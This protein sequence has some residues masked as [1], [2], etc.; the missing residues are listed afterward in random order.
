MEQ[1]LEI[2]STLFAPPVKGSI[3]VLAKSQ[4]GFMSMF[5]L[6]LFRSVSEIMPEMQFAVDQMESNKK[7]WE[8]KLVDAEHAEKSKQ[9]VEEM[10][11]VPSLNQTTT[12][13]QPHVSENVGS[14]SSNMPQ[15]ITTDS[16][17]EA[18][19]IEPTSQEALQ[20]NFDTRTDIFIAGGTHTYDPSRRSSLGS[21]H[22][23]RSSLANSL[24]NASSP[25]RASR[26]SSGAFPSTANQQFQPLGHSR[27]SSMTVPSSQLHLAFD[28]AIPRK[29]FD[30]DLEAAGA[31]DRRRS[32]NSIVAV[33]VTSSSSS[34]IQEGPKHDKDRHSN[35]GRSTPTTTHHSSNGSTNHSRYSKRHS[36][37]LSEDNRYSQATNFT[38]N[39]PYSPS[40]QATSLLSLA[41]KEDDSMNG[42][43]SQAHS[44]SL[45]LGPH[46]GYKT[47]FVAGLDGNS[48]D[49]RMGAKGYPLPNGGEDPNFGNGTSISETVRKLSKRPSRFRLG[50][51]KKGR[52][53]SD[54]SE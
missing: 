3:T 30:T 44:S 40:T 53:S 52:R 12:D 17:A 13:E 22:S 18:A 39:V 7:V 49:E 32:N 1:D 26:R 27:P 15:F 48:G 42:S 16:D 21:P 25:E 43:S 50:W 38:T 4:I 33:V 46:G 37:V 41:S 10:S 14:P 31:S 29:S 19:Q 51:W 35:E 2:P 6:P 5:A 23:R 20:P 11:G 36:S 34:T 54:R 24:A 47:G 45:S 8:G 28:P 9:D